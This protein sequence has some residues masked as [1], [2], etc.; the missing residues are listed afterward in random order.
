MLLDHDAFTDSV[1]G[2]REAGARFLT[3]EAVCGEGSE[4]EFV[5]HFGMGE[6]VRTLSTRTVAR[7]VPSLFSF[8]GAADFPEREAARAF[9][10]KFLGHPNLPRLGEER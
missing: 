3:L 7:A 6:E 8:Y 4:I 9:G 10:V 1:R 2:L 5:Y